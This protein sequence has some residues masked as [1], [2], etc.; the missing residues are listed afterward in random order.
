MDRLLG[1]LNY[2]GRSE[3][4]IEARLHEGVLSEGIR[5]EP[6]TESGE[7][8]DMMPVACPVPAEGYTEKRPWLD[9]LAYSTAELQKDRRSLPPAMRMVPYVR[10]GE[11][12]A[13]EGGQAT[14]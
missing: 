1:S 3:S 10:P 9:A 8:G 4:W 12:G 6:M 7:S 5:C 11:C 2:M 13:D 14:P